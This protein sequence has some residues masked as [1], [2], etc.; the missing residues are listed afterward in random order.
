M[1]HNGGKRKR[2][3]GWPEGEKQCERPCRVAKAGSLKFLSLSFL[4]FK[5][6][7]VLTALWGGPVRKLC[8][9]DTP[10]SSLVIRQMRRL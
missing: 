3:S 10:L 1:A 2:I 8:G 9:M 7:L 5:K 4:A 6:E